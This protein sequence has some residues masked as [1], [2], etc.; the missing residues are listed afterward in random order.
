M[1][2]YC[3]WVPRD[4]SDA[5]NDLLERWHLVEDEKRCL[6]RLL[7]HE[8]MKW[9][10]ELG[11]ASRQHWTAVLGAVIQLATTDWGELGRAKKSIKSRLNRIE[12]RS[13]ALALELDELEVASRGLAAQTTVQFDG[14]LPGEQVPL[15]SGNTLYLHCGAGMKKFEKHV[16]PRLRERQMDLFSYPSVA[17]MLRKLAGVASAMEK[18]DL[19]LV[20]AVRSGATT[21]KGNARKLKAAGNDSLPAFNAAVM[22]AFSDLAKRI[23][24]LSVLKELTQDQLASLAAAALNRPQGVATNTVGKSIARNRTRADKSKT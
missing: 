5:A 23:P 6:N 14:L 12:R 2:N 1:G 3:T 10:Y 20:G 9:F 19:Q 7:T 24:A 17:N 18:A 22:R 4:A 16:A 8:D 21:P 11:I 13:I 15:F